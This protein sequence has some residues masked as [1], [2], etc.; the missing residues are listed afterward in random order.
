MHLITRYERRNTIRTLVRKSRPNYLHL[1]LI[2]LA[3]AV[4]FLKSNSCGP[5]LHE[6]ITVASGNSAPKIGKEPG[7]A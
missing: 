4:L 2:I 7:S 6:I 5:D 3:I 1:V